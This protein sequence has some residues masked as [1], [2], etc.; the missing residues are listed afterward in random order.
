MIGLS[1]AFMPLFARL[2]RGQV[3]AV[4]G[5]ATSRRRSWSAAGPRA[6]SAATSCP[7]WPR[8]WSCRLDDPGVRLLAEGALAFLGLSVQPPETSL[9]SM[10]QRGSGASTTRRGWCSCP[11]WPSPS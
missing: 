8:R 5:R 2:V 9:G 1:V 3:L 7:T 11:G 6:S 4:R 10:L